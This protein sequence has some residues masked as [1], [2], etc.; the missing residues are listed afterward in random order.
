MC[1]I[2][3]RVENGVTAAV[4]PTTKRVKSNTDLKHRVVHDIIL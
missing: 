3:I 1:C 2:T 4:A